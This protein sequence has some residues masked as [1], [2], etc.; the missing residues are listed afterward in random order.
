M[1]YRSDRT[2][3]HNIFI[4]GEKPKYSEDDT[5]YYLYIPTEVTEVWWNDDYIVAKQ[6]ELVADERGYEQPPETPLT[7]TILIGS[8]M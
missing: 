7:V 8:L 1:D 6:I 4:Y 3:A 5:S 2:S